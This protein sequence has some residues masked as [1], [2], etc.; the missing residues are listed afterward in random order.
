MSDLPIRPDELHSTL[1]RHPTFAARNVAD[2]R[3]QHAFMDE[4]QAAL[5]LI[6]SL[7]EAARAVLMAWEAE[8]DLEKQDLSEEL[9]RAMRALRRAVERSQRP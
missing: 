8:D 1:H 4:A 2:P 5:D 9:W 6:P 3:L 7:L